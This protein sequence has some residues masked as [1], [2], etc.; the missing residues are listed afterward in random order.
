MDNGSVCTSSSLPQVAQFFGGMVIAL[1]SMGRGSKRNTGILRS[2]Q[3]DGGLYVRSVI[4][5]N[6]TS[7]GPV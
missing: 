5:T 6:G 1:L 4:G 2:A 7:S 3:D